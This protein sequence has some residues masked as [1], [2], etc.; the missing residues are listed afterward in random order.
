MIRFIVFWC[1]LF[2]AAAAGASPRIAVELAG[3]APLR[4]E[5][6]PSGFDL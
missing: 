4:A 5:A 2:A 1:H 6:R 3:C